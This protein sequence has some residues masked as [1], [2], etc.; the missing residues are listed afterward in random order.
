LFRQRDGRS[1]RDFEAS[2]I[3]RHSQQLVGAGIDQVAG[4]DIATVFPSLHEHMPLAGFE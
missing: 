1:A 2:Q 3:H 4:G